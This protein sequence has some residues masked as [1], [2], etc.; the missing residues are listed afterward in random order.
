MLRIQ[1]VIGDDGVYLPVPCRVGVLARTALEVSPAVR[2]RRQTKQLR[3]AENHASELDPNN[4]T[5]RVEVGSE[6]MAEAFIGDLV[7]CA[8]EGNSFNDRLWSAEIRACLYRNEARV[9]KPQSELNQEE[10]QRRQR[11]WRILANSFKSSAETTPAISDF[12]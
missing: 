4:R 12:M 1:R 8:F 7:L 5:V 6:D 10:Q 9:E 2:K 3:R 11:S